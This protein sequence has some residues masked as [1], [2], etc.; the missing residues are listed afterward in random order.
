M[1]VFVKIGGGGLVEA[2]TVQQAVPDV[3]W[4]HVVDTVTD[5]ATEVSCAYSRIPADLCRGQLQGGEIVQRPALDP[6]T[7]DA[8]T[9]TVTVPVCPVGTQIMVAD[10]VAKTVLHSGL[11][12]TTEPTVISL[13]DAGSYEVEL[14]PP[15]PAL[16]QS[17]RITVDA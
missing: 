16:E 3:G 13:P 5:P 7:W 1:P 12:D 8:A 17:I 10:L 9:K 15:L 11:A 6:I 4:K 14:T 2:A